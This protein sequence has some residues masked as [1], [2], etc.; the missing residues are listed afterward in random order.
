[1]VKNFHTTGLQL[2]MQPLLMEVM[3]GMFTTF[4]VR[5]GGQNVP[6][7]LAFI[8][9]TWPQ[10]FPGKAFESKF[11]EDNLALGYRNE[12]RMARLCADFAGVAIF[13]SC[14][15]LFGLIS[16]TVRQRAKEVGNRKVLGASVAAIVGLLS[17]DFLKLVVL[18]IAI[19][20]PVAYFLMKKW[21]GS[22]VYRIEIGLSVFVAAALAAVALAFLTISFQA[23]KAALADPVK[24]LRSE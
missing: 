3:S 13:L 6:A 16:F 7:T 23:I 14:F 9:K 2:A 10:F 15:G 18:A 21:L 1:M 22:F 20:A 4:G 8:E 5:L 17:R 12:Q 19:A 24:S 11:L